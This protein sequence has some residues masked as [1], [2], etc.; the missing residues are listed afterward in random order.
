MNKVSFLVL[1]LFYVNVAKS[2]IYLHYGCQLHLS[3]LVHNYPFQTVFSLVKI[4]QWSNHFLYIMSQ[5]FQFC[6]LLNN[7]FST[8]GQ[9]LC[10][11]ILFPC[12]TCLFFH[13]YH[14]I[15]SDYILII[16]ESSLL[17]SISKWTVIQGHLCFYIDFSKCFL[18]SLKILLV[19]DLI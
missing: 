2:I 12:S 6:F 8:Q 9:F 4:Q 18:N 1:K 10:F 3:L 19:S 7:L 17:C 16:A 13:K 14:I 15:S 5:F 11:L